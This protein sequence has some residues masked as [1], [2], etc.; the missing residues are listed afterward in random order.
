MADTQ[1]SPMTPPPATE[2]GTI[3]G[4][5]DDMM[6]YGDALMTA[7]ASVGVPQLAPPEETFA[8]A[9][10]G[11]SAWLT[12]R[13][14]LGL[15]TNSANKNSWIRIQGVGWRKLFNAS[16]TAVVC[17]TMLAAH[18]RAEKRAVNARIE[19]DNRVHELYVW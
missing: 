9:E 15:W 6:A 1:Q 8:A 7:K 13:K 11:I 14:I 3:N 19:A 12:N 4:R 5:P 18:A 2:T 10:E 17:M 16:E